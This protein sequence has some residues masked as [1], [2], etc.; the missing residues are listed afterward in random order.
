M[1]MGMPPLPREHHNCEACILG[2]H[3]RTPIPK[4]RQTPTIRILELVYS[5]LCGPFPSKSLTGSRYILTFIDDFSRYSWVYFLSAKSET[6]S[7]FKSF[8]LMV[9]KQTHHK[10]SALRTDRGGEYLSIDFNTYCKLQGIRR[11]L[12]AAGT[13]QHNG[14]AER[15]NR[16]LLETMRSLLFGS[17]L[18]SYLWGEAVRTANYISNRVPTKALYRKVLFSKTRPLSLKNIW[19]DSLCSHPK[20]LQT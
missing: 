5:D 8:K 4:T 20:V 1:V 3:H 7:V 14:I 10:L 16:Y 9:E 18:P 13:P 2:K 12:T 19:L 17:R 15:K 6:F 11:H